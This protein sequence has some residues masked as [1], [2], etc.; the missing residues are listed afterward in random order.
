MARTFKDIA[1]LVI[2]KVSN[3]ESIDS[4]FDHEEFQIHEVEGFEDTNRVEV[5][6]AAERFLDIE[7][8]FSESQSFSEYSLGPGCSRKKAV[9]WDQNY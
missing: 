6:E 9:T 4:L 7:E 2:D 1:A 8:S 3:K 5:R